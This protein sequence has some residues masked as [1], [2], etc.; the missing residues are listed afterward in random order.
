MSSSAVLR[1]LGV[2]LIIA[3]IARQP[4]ATLLCTLLLLAAGVAR[5]WNHWSLARVGY[6]AKLSATRAFPG[7]E[8]DL[9]LEVTNRKPLPLAALTVRE[10]L[11]AGL[12][13]L[14]GAAGRD[15][16]GRQVLRRTAGLGWYEG[17]AWQ[18]R[19]RC[20]ARG[21]Y[22]LGPATL[23]AGDPFGFFMSLRDEP[24]ATRLLVFPR[25]LPL[26]ELRL[27]SRRP[28]GDLRA[29][30]LVRDPLRTVG[31]RDYHPEDPLKDIH[32]TAT[33][34]TGALQTR[35]YEPTVQRSLAIFLDLD[36]FERYWEG[37]DLEQVER[38]IS[39]AATV[40]HAGLAEG[41]AV[42]L[43]V[44][45]APAEHEQLV[46][47]P[48]SRSPAQL[49]R[50]ME[51]LAGL[52]P[53][54]ITPMASLLHTARP[55]IGATILL[56][57]AIAPEATR[58]ALLGLRERGRAVGWLWLADAPPPQVPGIYTHHA[59]AREDWRKAS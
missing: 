35:V 28:L 16:H 1:F 37:L 10:L 46:H 50:I 33:A 21:A 51:T 52:T 5:L 13:A 53:Y 44:N 30:M 3:L 34:R 9:R 22:R 40:A 48:P 55:P 11:P 54:S 47:L 4:L 58:A 41:D 8:I 20:D 2:L 17:L 36:T 49:E 32:W 24:Q 39:A 43:Y 26:A 31:A 42:G 14:E 19:L 59:P 57:S 7:D 15:F 45:G 12:T 56:V 38:L 18:Y 6:Q 27:P 29:H 25:L 23:E